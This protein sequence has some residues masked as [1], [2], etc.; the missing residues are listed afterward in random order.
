MLTLDGD[1]RVRG[2][3]VVVAGGRAPC[4]AEL[5]LDRVGVQLGPRGIVVDEY[6]RAAEGVWAIGDVT[7]VA[8][9]SHLAQ[10]Q[11]R[12]AADAILGHPHPADYVAAPRVLFT[13][14]QVA[15]TGF[16]RAQLREQGVDL[17]TI[18]VDLPEQSEHWEASAAAHALPSGL[19][20]LHADRARGVLVGAWVVAPDAAN[21]IQFAAI[22]IRAAI[23]LDVARDMLQQFPAFGD[24]YLF[25]I[26]RLLEEL[27]RGGD[28]TQQQHG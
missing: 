6:C 9:L 20:T 4:T 23:P 8:P 13:N 21:W 26:D 11:A 10:Y 28:G 18:T 12:I 16:T 1:T 19:L 3:Q 17:L 15:V 2:R 22:A 7:G 14:P 27:H 5:G 25:A 24:V